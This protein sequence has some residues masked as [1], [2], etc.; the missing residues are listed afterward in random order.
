MSL[1]QAIVSASSISSSGGG[2]SPVPADIYF[3]SDN[4]QWN[5]YGTSLSGAN[6]TATYGSY[7][8]PNTTIGNVFTFTGNEVLYSPNLG[9][10]NA[11]AVN[12]G[13]ITVDFW[14]YPTGNGMQ[15]LSETNQQ[16]M[17]GY[18]ATVLEVDGFNYIKARFYNGSTGTSDN[19]ITLNQWNHV[20]WAADSQGGHYLEVNGVGTNTG[21]YYTRQGPGNNSEFFAIGDYDSTNMGAS[22]RFQGKFGALNIH[23]SLVSSTFMAT[24]SKYGL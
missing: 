23:D 14:F 15:L 3:S 11:W 13:T 16:N 5:G 12:G 8:Y 7:T 1:L 21:L 17:V 10:P 4:N 18:H 2:G 22:G 20:Y 9:N 19:T 24:K 6:W